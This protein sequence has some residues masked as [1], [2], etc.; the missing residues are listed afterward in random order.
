MW[1]REMATHVRV[2]EDDPEI[3]PEGEATPMRS[4]KDG[5]DE[6]Q[7]CATASGSDGDMVEVEVASSSKTKD[8][9]STGDKD[10]E[11]GRDGQATSLVQ[12]TRPR[13]GRSPPALQGGHTQGQAP[14]PSELTNTA[15]TQPDSQLTI[16][17]VEDAL[18]RAAMTMASSQAEGGDPGH[19]TG[20]NHSLSLIEFTRKRPKWDRTLGIR[21]EPHG[22]AKT[23]KPWTLKATTTRSVTRGCTWH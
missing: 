11:E 15:M 19:A 3:R 9:D 18:A 20:G 22:R 4:L 2:E 6:A 12:S 8:T 10:D 21:P 5:E 13:H 1:A 16:E 7:D 17:N 23:S 14:L